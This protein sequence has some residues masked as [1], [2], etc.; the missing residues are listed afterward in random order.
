[1]TPRLRYIWKRLQ[2]PAGRWQI[3]RGL[4]FSCWPLVSRLA[5]LHRRTLARRV[6]VVAVIGSYGKTT[7]TRATLVALGLPLR[8]QNQSNAWSNVAGAILRIMPWHRYAVIEVGI[9]GVGQMARYASIVKPDIVVVTSIG[10]EHRRSLG[11][12]ETTRHEKADMA[13]ALSGGGM[14]VVNGDD[15]NV[16]WMGAQTTACKMSF[17]FAEANHVRASGA[18]LDWPNGTRF[19]LHTGDQNRRVCVRLIGETMLYPVLAAIA[20]A[21]AEGFELTQVLARLGQLPPTPGRLEPLE[22]PN[23]AWILR[24]DFKSGLETFD[25]AL[26]A[27]ELISA[28]RRWVVFGDVTEPP[29]SQGP[30]YRRI[31]ERVGLSADRFVIVGP[32]A[33][34]YATGAQASGLHRSAISAPG[35]LVSGALKLLSAELRLG[36]V[37]LIKGRHDQRLERVTLALQGHEVRCDIERCEVKVHSCANCPMLTR[38]WSFGSSQHRESDSENPVSPNDLR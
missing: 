28:H 5:W 2:T 15:A 8:W 22:L 37:I 23:G 29:G 25:P 7:T 16:L 14:V 13:R 38:G 27:L 33:Q 30:I 31:G 11:S 21:Q 12:E 17:G 4:W 32:N 9:D 26:A 20:V 36:D 35:R 1:M 34:R 6:R 19:T 3:G 18:E 24:D 10:S